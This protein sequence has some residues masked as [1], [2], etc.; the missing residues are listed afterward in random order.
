MNITPKLV[1]SAATAVL[2]TLASVQANA[3]ISYQFEDTLTVSDGDLWANGSWN[4]D[5][6]S[7][8]YRVTFDGSYW[9][10]DYTWST[11]GKDLSHVI[12]EL[13]SGDDP[14]TYDNLMGERHG[15]ISWYG[16][17]PDEYPNYRSNPG[18]PD[19]IYG[20]KYD[21]G[22][23][24]DFVTYSIITDRG[25]MWGDTYFKSGSCKE[26][27]STECFGY[28]KT[29][30]YNTGWP[31]P[32][33]EIDWINDVELISD[34]LYGLKDEAIIRNKILVPDSFEGRPPSEIPVPAAA[35][36]FGSGLI[37]LAGAARRRVRGRF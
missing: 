1:G 15:E 9:T 18:I 13:T 23:G 24:G 6:T 29:L 27:G 3:A 5:A 19:E 2:L 28:D 35:W 37:G 10:Y 16:P 11:E 31:D 4:N 30:A 33:S 22:G 7:L 25:P 20:I 26:R 21:M 36:L 34:S 12:T 32:D 14:F 17:D 8:S